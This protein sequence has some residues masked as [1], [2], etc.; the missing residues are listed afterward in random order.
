MPRISIQLEPRAVSMGWQEPIHILLVEL[1][2]LQKNLLI[3]HIEEKGR[4]P[5]LESREN[6]KLKERVEEEQ[7]CRRPKQVGWSGPWKSKK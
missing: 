3:T 7:K 2:L 1:I 4:G 6:M 5:R